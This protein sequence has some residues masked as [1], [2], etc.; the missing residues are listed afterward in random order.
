MVGDVILRSTFLYFVGFGRRFR[1]VDIFVR[2]ELVFVC[3]LIY[4]NPQLF[5]TYKVRSLCGARSNMGAVADH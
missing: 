2:E 4:L 1:Q 5:T 3:Y